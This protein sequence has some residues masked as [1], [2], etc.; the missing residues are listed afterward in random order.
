MRT[1]QE[2]ATAFS[3]AD[4]INPE[5]PFVMLGIGGAG[6]SPLAAMLQRHGCQVRGMDSTLSPVTD[7]LSTL[8]IAV[9]DDATELN[10]SSKDQVVLSDAIDLY[11]DDAVLRARELGC[12]LFRRS[13]LLGWLLREKKVIAITGTHGKTTT[14]SMVGI[15]L[16]AAGLDPTIIVGAMV[17]QFG[18]L[19]IEGQSDWAV[20]E[21]CEAYDSFHDL[22]P[23]IIVLTNLELDHVDFHGTYANLRDSVKRFVDALPEGG[24]LI[25]CAEDP[26]AAEVAASTAYAVSYRADDWSQDLLIGGR[27]NRQNAAAAQAVLRYLGIESEDANRALSRFTGADR[28]LQIVRAGKVSDVG[29]ASI[30]VV[31]DYAHHPTEIVATIQALREMFPHRRLVLVFQPHLY[32]RT[33]DQVPEFAEALSMA[34]FVVLTDIY[35]AREAPMPGVSSARIAELLSVPNAYVPSRHLLPRK[36]AKMVQPNDVVV[37]MGAGNISEFAPEFVVE[38]AR[39]TV[40]DILDRKSPARILVAYGGDSAEREVSLHS[41]LAVQAALLNRGH[42]VDL[43]DLS[44]VLLMGRGMSFLSGSKRPDVVFL[45]VHGTNAEDGAIQGL[46]EL[47]HIPYTGASVQSSA[48]CMDKQATKTRLMAAGIRV[49]YGQLVQHGQSVTYPGHPVVVKPNAQGSTVGL[50]FVEFEE[51]F[52]P[53]LERGFAYDRSLLVEEWV[54][55]MEISVPVLGDRALNPV[56]IAPTS[57]RY[58]FASKYLPGATE[59]VV[60]ARL[61]EDVLLMA[62]RIALQCHRVMDCSGA[63]RT[64]MIVTAEPDHEIIVL[65]VN[66]L[67]GMTQTSLLPNSARSL[68]IDMPELCEWI[69]FDA[70]ERYARR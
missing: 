33:A 35:P 63:T 32:S 1:K 70:I 48:L 36:V 50:S 3:Q 53:A 58:D 28:R 20:V 43:I 49:P 60:P 24:A 21:A 47:L 22:S 30:T 6:M 56:E 45:A 40:A 51:A 10:L 41:G 38:L 14:T 19:I 44:E 65:E 62:Q 11:A 37:G 55:G 8:G 26:G 27:H 59:E 67:P 12:P 25:F 69:A 54:R 46:L 42:D 31:D 13:Q 9:T 18:A 66:T 7:Q 68:G 39:P 52:I 16:R 64:D 29:N 23:K 5:R 2:I 17:P 4:C 15:A 34:D 61:P 57:G